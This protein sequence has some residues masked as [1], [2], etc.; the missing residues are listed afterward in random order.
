VKR[1]LVRSG[2]APHEATVPEAAFA[3]AGKATYAMNAGNLVY[4]EAVYRLLATPDVEVVS[5]SLSTERAGVTKA[6]I[7]RIN[8]EFDAFVLPMANSLRIGFAPSRARLTEVIRQLKIPVVVVGIGAQLSPKVDWHWIDDE[9]KAN[10]RAFVSAVLDHSA[11]IGVRG[12]A[13]RSYLLHLGFHDSQI[14]VIGCPS[15]H[16]SGRDAVIERKVDAL[17]PDSPIAVNADHRIPGTEKVVTDNSHFSDL[18]FVSQNQAEAALLMW[19]KP[20]ADYPAGLPGTIDH[21]LYREDRVRFF[22][23]PRPW[24]EFMA[25][26]D[27]CLG[28]R[29][30]GTIAA[31]MAGTPA[32]VV[33]HDSRLMELCR[34]H[35]IPHRMIADV[36]DEPWDAARFYEL[37]DPEPMNR[38]RAE[39][40]DRYLAFIERNGLEHIHQPGKANPA[41]D[42][43]L[44][45]AAHPGALRPLTADPDQVASRLRW[46]WQDADGD[47]TR[48]VGAYQPPF[49]PTPAELGLEDRVKRLEA[50]VAKQEKTLKARANTLPRRAWRKVR[51]TFGA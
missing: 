27:F 18:V 32:M 21:P 28:S 34:Y 41:Y 10:Q 45:E 12:E 11:S 37:A 44:A 40:F 24:R 35:Q 3:H 38:V 26:R 39:N 1:I 22:A 29:M 51:R 25:T 46:L 6:H 13:T 17:R 14:D 2:K 4:T 42:A 31:L 8:A 5:D 49:A 47:R 20:I 30:H 36:I 19:G 9:A 16:D 7:D 50:K 33:A 15:M 43:V 23:D 48:A